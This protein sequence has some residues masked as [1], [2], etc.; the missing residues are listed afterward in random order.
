MFQQIIATTSIKMG[1]HC[2]AR[3]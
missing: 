2:W 3:Y 1:G